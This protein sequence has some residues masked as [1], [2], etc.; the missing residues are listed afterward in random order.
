MTRDDSQAKR[1]R[2]TISDVAAALGV[3]VSTVSNAYNR[4]DQ[5][6]AELRARVF[7]VAAQLGYPGPDPVA[8]SLRQHRAGAIGVLFAERLSYAFTDPAALLVLD[9]IAYLVSA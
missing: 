7:E 1:Q 2:V 6:S 4:P 3:A 9:G 5:L 8:R